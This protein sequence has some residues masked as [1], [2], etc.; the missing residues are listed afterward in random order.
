MFAPGCAPH[1][2]SAVTRSVDA[3]WKPCD[4]NGSFPRGLSGNTG[5]PAAAYARAASPRDIACSTGEL[6]PHP[7]RARRRAPLRHGAAVQDLMSLMSRTVPAPRERI[8]RDADE[9]SDEP[10][11][12]KRGAQSEPDGSAAAD[13][14]PGEASSER[15]TAPRTR[16]HRSER[17][18][19]STATEPSATSCRSSP[20]TRTSQDRRALDGDHQPCRRLHTHA[21]P[22]VA[23][24]SD[25]KG[26]LRKTEPNPES[27]TTRVSG[28]RRAY[29]RR[30]MAVRKVYRAG[31]IV[32][33]PQRQVPPNGRRQIDATSPGSTGRCPAAPRHIPKSTPIRQPTRSKRYYRIGQHHQTLGFA[34][35][36]ILLRAGL[37]QRHLK[38]SDRAEGGSL[39]ML[40][41]T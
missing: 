25:G 34:E 31:R 14:S 26:G 29:V 19:R 4:V 36:K 15:S 41:E 21:R 13:S 39:S 1:R 33:P 16:H 22:T 2:S 20:T 5:S 35:T 17:S 24:A 38:K 18:S 11:G 28:P 37:R 10:G 40:Q 3:S 27:A 9:A 12:S 8:L 6:T 7:S 23:D 30:T 32:R